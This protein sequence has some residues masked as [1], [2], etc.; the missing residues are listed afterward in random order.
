MTAYTKKMA[1]KITGNVSTMGATELRLTA[2]A[3]QAELTSRRNSWVG[4]KNERFQELERSGRAV[5]NEVSDPADY[6]RNDRVVVT[7]L[8]KSRSKASV[9][10]ARVAPGDRYDFRIGI[11][12]AFARAMGEEVP[13]LF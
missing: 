7:V 2:N 10:M 1:K 3:A 8:D 13:D 5:V 4:E 9:G 11:A 12:I 6:W